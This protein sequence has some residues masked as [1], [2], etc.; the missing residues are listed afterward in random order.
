M[1]MGALAAAMAADGGGESSLEQDGGRA[2]G[3]CPCV[4]EIGS[5]EEPTNGA[6]TSDG[7]FGNFSSACGACWR[8]FAD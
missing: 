1:A 4:G 8:C 3:V 5:E 7:V 6:G 2:G